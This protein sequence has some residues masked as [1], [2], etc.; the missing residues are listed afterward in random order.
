MVQAVPPFHPAPESEK[1][2]I[3]HQAVPSVQVSLEIGWENLV[4]QPA[5][6]AFAVPAPFV[7]VVEAADVSVL[8]LVRT[9]LQDA[10][11]EPHRPHDPDADHE[12]H[13]PGVVIR[14]FARITPDDECC[15]SQSGDHDD[16]HQPPDP[17]ALAFFAGEDPPLP[18]AGPD[19][20]E[21]LLIQR[22]LGRLVCLRSGRHLFRCH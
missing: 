14:G 12:P 21:P 11:D 19:L 6:H 3:H 16:P 8:R 18:I 4:D 15:G 20:L 17:A 9:S 22:R 2:A 5:D 13:E 1:D 7:E 10:E